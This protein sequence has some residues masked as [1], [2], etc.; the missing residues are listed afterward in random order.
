MKRA[1]KVFKEKKINEVREREIEVKLHQ[2]KVD[3]LCL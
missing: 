3:F 1:E 2:K